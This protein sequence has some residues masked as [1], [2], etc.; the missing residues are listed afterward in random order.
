MCTQVYNLPLPRA[1]L[2]DQDSDTDRETSAR[3]TKLNTDLL[4]Q[5]HV[6]FNVSD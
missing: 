2:C 4:F 6:L 1:L 3:R 5:R